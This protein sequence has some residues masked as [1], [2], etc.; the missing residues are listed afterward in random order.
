MDWEV[1]LKMADEIH[2]LRYKDLKRL[3]PEATIVRE[4]L[5]GLTKS[6]MV[7]R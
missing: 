5:A 7:F 6:F 2:L 4:R 1:S 3:F